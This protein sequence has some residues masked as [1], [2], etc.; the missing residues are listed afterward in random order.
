MALDGRFSDPLTTWGRYLASKGRS[1][2]AAE[3][4]RGALA[5]NPADRAAA[6]G[7]AALEK[8]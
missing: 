2:E 6:A 8:R 7:L 5:R 3:A 1:D 4:F